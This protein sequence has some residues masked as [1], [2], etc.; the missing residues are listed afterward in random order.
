MN[1]KQLNMNNL[2]KEQMEI[3][4]EVSKNLNLAEDISSVVEKSLDWIIKFLQVERAIFVKY[5]ID[6]ND[7]TIISARNLK[8]ETIS[9]LHLF[10]S[11]ILREIVKSKKPLLH[12]DIQS[13]PHFSQYESI[14]IHQIKSILGVPI[15]QSENLWGVILVDSHKNRINFTEDNLFFLEFFGSLISLALNKIIQIQNLK[16]EY[17][18]L[19]NRLG[20]IDEIPEIVGVSQK[21]KDLSRM[22]HKVAKTDATVLITGESGVGKELVA[23][24]IHKLSNR[25]TKPFIAQFCGSIPDSL[26]ESELFGYKRGA[27]TGANTDKKGLFEIA[28]EG[29]FFLD[30]IADIS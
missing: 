5:L 12:H 4:F 16:D 11:G 3:L 19:S 6:E 9:D 8:K 26:L 23:N 10:S 24:A 20:A 14:Q 18:I 29:T 2:T 1:I 27:F 30:E 21:T 7:F 13:D 17:E 15:F 22:I 25:N 28:N